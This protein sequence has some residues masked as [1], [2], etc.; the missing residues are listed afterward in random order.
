M[1]SK[2][3]KMKFPDLVI[4]IKVVDNVENYLNEISAKNSDAFSRKSQKTS[5]FDIKLLIKKN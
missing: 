5:F 4:N 1:A 3:M 2:W